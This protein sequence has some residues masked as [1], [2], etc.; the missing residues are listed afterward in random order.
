MSCSLMAKDLRAVHHPDKRHVEMPY[1]PALLVRRGS[2]LFLSGLT[3]AP[4]YHSH[5]HREEEFDLP[6]RMRDQAVLVMENL[7]TTLAAAGCALSDVVAA[8][9]YLT[10]VAEQDDLNAVWASYLGAHRPTTTT[11]EVSRLAT[12]ANCK[13]E[14]SVIA[15]ADDMAARSV[16]RSGRA[17][18]NGRARRSR[19]RAERIQEKP[20]GS[21]RKSA[22]Q[23]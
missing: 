12:H 16:H 13:I 2:L 14:I 19:R 1:A 8:T 15:L 9:R 10:D 4:V 3:A 17:R 18:R 5:P 22:R 11:V 7:K 23:K 20:K 21:K 6:P